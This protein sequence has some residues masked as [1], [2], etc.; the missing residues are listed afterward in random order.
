MRGCSLRTTPLGDNSCVTPREILSVTDH[1]PWPLPA[2]PWVMTQTWTNLLF[3]HWPLPPDIIRPLVPPMLPLD[4]YD[5][6]AWVAVAPFSISGLRM[7]GM[8]ALPVISRFP[9]LNVRTYVTLDGKPGVFFFSLD[10]A[11]LSAVWAARNFYYLPYYHAKMSAR[12]SGEDVQYSCR[13]WSKRKPAEFLGEYRPIAPVELRPRGT[14]ENFLTERYCL[15]SLLG[16]RVYR[17][18]IHH[19]QWPLQNASAEIA[20]N[21]MAAAAGITLPAERPLL[22]FSRKLDVLVWT[23]ERCR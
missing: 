7:R 19:E 8:P 2:R 11:N 22:H 12:A 20:R 23:P 1:R 3:A 15:Y 21:T 14:L 9:E 6:R 18:E 16:P 4:L 17:A 10:A 13:R 5:G